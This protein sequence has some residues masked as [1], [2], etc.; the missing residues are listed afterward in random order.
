MRVRVLGKF[1][2]LV[3]KRLSTVDGYCDSPDK[4]G[5]EI[6]IDA[7][8]RGEERLRVLIHEAGHAANWHASEEWVDE[9]STDL[10]RVL[11]RLGYK[12]DY[13]HCQ[14]ETN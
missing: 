5:K 14:D 12:N 7:R 6:Q 9:F 10:A 1:W 3:F 13:E 11:T 2:N 8:L 4:P